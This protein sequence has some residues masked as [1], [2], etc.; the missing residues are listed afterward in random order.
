MIW[1]TKLSPIR[2]TGLIKLSLIRAGFEIFEGY[3]SCSFMGQVINNWHHVPFLPRRGKKTVLKSQ[4]LKGDESQDEG[5]LESLSTRC[6]RRYTSILLP[7][8]QFY[9]GGWAQWHAKQR[10]IRKGFRWFKCMQSNV[11][12]GRGW[13][14]LHPEQRPVWAGFRS[15]QRSIR[16][17]FWRI[18][19]DAS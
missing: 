10:P 3:L 17:G 2:R 7:A 18:Y 11:P 1:H 13:E 12:F 8:S 5:P 16:A 6:A 14:I 15:F 9:I 4:E 19:C